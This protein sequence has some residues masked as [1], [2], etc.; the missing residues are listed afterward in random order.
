M[1]QS[2]QKGKGIK[3]GKGIFGNTFENFDENNW[4]SCKRCGCDKF[5][6]DISPYEKEFIYRGFGKSYAFIRCVC[7]HHTTHHYLK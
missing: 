1:S 4:G 5:F 2:I 3:T 7:G 6:T